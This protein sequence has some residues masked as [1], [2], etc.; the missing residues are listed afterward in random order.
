[1]AVDIGPAFHRICLLGV[2]FSPEQCACQGILLS[3]LSRSPLELRFNLCLVFL[4]GEPRVDRSVFTWRDCANQFPRF[5]FSRGEF[6]E[7]RG[8]LKFK[9]PQ[10]DQGNL[11]DRFDGVAASGG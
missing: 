1:M 9:R 6:S 11:Q 2:S 10:G 5:C 3:Y 8:R 4:L 7:Q